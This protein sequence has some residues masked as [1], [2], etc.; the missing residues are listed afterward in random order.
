MNENYMYFV[1]TVTFHFEFP[2]AK[3]DFNK[4]MKILPEEAII[5][6]IK[7]GCTLLV[8]ALILSDELSDI[9]YIN[10]CKMIVNSIESKLNSSKGKLI[11]GNL[12]KKLSI[13]IPMN[14]DIKEFYSKRSI[15]IL[16]NTSI[17]EYIDFDDI[18]KVVQK[19]LS[20]KKNKNLNFIYDKY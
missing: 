14:E 1:P 11:V 6:N 3:I 20:P 9:E 13:K 2:P 16:Q 12:L 7:K 8:I 17:L 15:N 10:Q 5:I 19:K 18:K 4:L